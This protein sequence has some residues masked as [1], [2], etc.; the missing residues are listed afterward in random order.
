MY[1]C[2]NFKRFLRLLCIDAL[3][4]LC[5]FIT[6]GAIGCFNAEAG[7]EDENAIAVPIIMYHSV[8][9]NKNEPYIISPENLENDLKYLSQNGYKT[10]F[11]SQLADYV[12]NGK[13]LPEKPVIITFDDGFYNN[14]YYA[15]P[16]LEKYD[17]CAVISVVGNYIT[18]VAPQD[19]HQPA[20]AYLIWDDLPELLDSGRIEIGNHTYN[21]HT[22]VVRKGCMRK[23]GESEESYVSALTADVGLLQSMI[24]TATGYSPI[25]FAYPLGFI[26]DES[27]PVLRELGFKITL[28][29]YEGVN[30]ITSN[31]ECLYGLKRFNRDGA[32]STEEFMLKIQ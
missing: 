30:K 3:I 25:T 28:S 15:L 9:K 24:Y 23:P 12:Y 10:I 4:F 8:T 7:S 16:L 11:A 6:A 27:V 20:Y 26:S 1:R 31:P 18:S 17:M 32:L 29:Y 5:L 13:L 22:S 19:V 14:L 2:C 21:M